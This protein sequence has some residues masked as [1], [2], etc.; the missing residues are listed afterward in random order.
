MAKLPPLRVEANAPETRATRTG[1]LGFSAVTSPL[2]FPGDRG[3]YLDIHHFRPF[4]WQPAQQIT[5]IHPMRRI[6]DLRHTFATFALRAGIS[7]FDLSRYMGASLTM[8]DRHYGHLAHD[9]REHAIKL[10]DALNAPW[11]LVGATWTPK[12][13]IGVSAENESD[14]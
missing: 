13:P 2:L 14:V 8:I 7:T 1:Q 10:L 9:G 6:Y 11:T 12:E 3:G 4:H 5:G